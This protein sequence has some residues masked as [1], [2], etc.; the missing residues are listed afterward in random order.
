VRA[1]V[2]HARGAVRDDTQR[3]RLN[4]RQ[5]FLAAIAV[6][7]NSWKLDNFRKPALVAFLLEFESQRLSGHR[8]E[9]ST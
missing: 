2:H 1:R 5:G 9:G 4:L 8:G 7:K 6:G 3:E